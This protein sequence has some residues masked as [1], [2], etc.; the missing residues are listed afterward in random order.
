MLVKKEQYAFSRKEKDGTV[1]V[2]VNMSNQPVK[3]NIP[4]KG[5]LAKG[6]TDFLNPDYCLIPN[7][8]GLSV[9]VPP[10]WGRILYH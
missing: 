3:V 9:E 5:L 2:I 7:K 8:T 6:F 10:C 1:V 4:V